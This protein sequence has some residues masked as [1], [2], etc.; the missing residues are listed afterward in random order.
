[1]LQVGMRDGGVTEGEGEGE[2]EEGVTEGRL[3]RDDAQLMVM[4]PLLLLM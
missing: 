4:L 1:M 2:E 3:R